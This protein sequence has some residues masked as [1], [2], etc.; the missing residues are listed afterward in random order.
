AYT[1]SNPVFIPV[2]ITYPGSILT[3]KDNLGKTAKVDMTK[4]SVYPQNTIAID[5]I[6][7]IIDDAF[8]A[9]Y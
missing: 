7:Q 4:P 1:P 6:I 5:G 3:V 9:Q 8:T 2:T